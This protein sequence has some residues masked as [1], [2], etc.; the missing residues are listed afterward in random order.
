MEN[1]FNIFEAVEDI[2]TTPL[3]YTF[4][5]NTTLNFNAVDFYNYLLRKCTKVPTYVDGALTW[6]DAYDSLVALWQ[7][8]ILRTRANYTKLKD[9]LELEYDV[10][11]NYNGTT[12][13]TMT[14]TYDK[15]DTLSFNNRSDTTT[16]NNTDTLSFNNRTDT[17]TLNNSDTLS[18][19][20]R[21]DTQ[22]N[23]LLSTDTLNDTTTTTN[24]GQVQ[25]EQYSVGFNGETPK[26]ASK[27]LTT[28]GVDDIASEVSEVART[29]TDSTADTGTV[30]N[31][32]AGSEVNS[33][34][35][36]ITNDKSGS[37]VNAH[38][39]TITD[40]K[41]GEEVNSQSGTITHS[42]EETKS[43]NLGVTTSQQM[44]SSEIQLRVEYN[45]KDI[46]LK[47][48]IKEYCYY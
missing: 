46:I 12:I 5:D 36:T 7:S 8:F 30:T 25:V 21:L 41:T 17:E 11:D 43:G 26:L 1:E 33:H 44:L 42:Y 35:G 13:S 10:L 48:F 20:N 14:D 40:A 32:K 29:G 23:N 45:L 3:V 19:N 24:S 37:E 39:G 22:T 18:F 34:S 27:E 9:A 2:Q 31:A 15:D 47:E 38:S 28:R 16:L 6:L 4:T